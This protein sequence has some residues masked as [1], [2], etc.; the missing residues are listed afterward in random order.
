LIKSD[1]TNANRKEIRASSNIS[2]RFEK[3]KSESFI[4]I[5]LFTRENIKLHVLFYPVNII[6]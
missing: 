4:C 5:D 6:L 3:E 2:F 1:V